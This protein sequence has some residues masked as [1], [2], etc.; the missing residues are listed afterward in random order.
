M[1]DS[2]SKIEKYHFSVMW[3]RTMDWIFFPFLAIILSMILKYF[4]GYKIHNLK[5]VRTKYRTICKQRGNS[6]LLI[7]PNH[8][9]MIDSIILEW[10][11]ASPIWL[12]FNFRDFPWNIPAIENFKTNT[13]LKILTYLGKCIP[14]DRKGG[15]QHTDAVLQKVKFLLKQ[16]DAFLIFPEGT[17]S[18]SARFELDQLAYGVGQIVQ[19][20]KKCYV[21]CVYI[22]GDSQSSFSRYPIKNETMFIEM[23]MIK[24]TSDLQGLRAQKDIT[25]QIGQE[26]HKL[27]TEYFQARGEYVNR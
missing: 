11:L 24:P 17:R 21:L 23:K 20:L 13:V 27:E 6:P 22:R 8:L 19:D 25:L 5:E 15:K 2:T 3:Q 10:A 4:M 14:I 18:R 9:T 12:W 1:T 26:I 16:G 7:C